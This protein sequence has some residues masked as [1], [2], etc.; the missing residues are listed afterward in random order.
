MTS[1]RLESTPSTL[2]R[3]FSDISTT[4]DNNEVTN[5]IHF[6]PTY[7]LFRT[8]IYFI[9]WFTRHILPPFN[10]AES[11]L[12]KGGHQ[13]ETNINWNSTRN[14]NCKRRTVKKGWISKYNSKILVTGKVDKIFNFNHCQY[15]IMISVSWILMQGFC[16]KLLVPKRQLIRRKIFR[17]IYHYHRQLLIKL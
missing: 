14:G 7:Y 13:T 1:K 11:C 12:V 16:W 10:F 6:V 15:F 5:S 3:N 9:E 17:L 2:K 8:N 4:Q